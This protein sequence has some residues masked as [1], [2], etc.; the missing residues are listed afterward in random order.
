MLYKVVLTHNPQDFF[1]GE[2]P[3]ILTIQ[4]TTKNISD[5]AK[6][7]KKGYVAIVFDVDNYDTMKGGFSC[8]EDQDC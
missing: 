8:D 7:M 1:N 6:Y 3:D 5:V 2:E 4:F